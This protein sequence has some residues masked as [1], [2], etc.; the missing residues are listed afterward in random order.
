MKKIKKDATGSQAIRDLLAV[1]RDK[2][3]VVRLPSD[4]K[5]I[6]QPGYR[7]NA[8]TLHN[9]L[10]II[11]KRGENNHQY[12]LN[13]GTLLRRPQDAM[14]LATRSRGR[15]RNDLNEVWK[16]M[17]DNSFARNVI[18]SNQVTIMP[19]SIKIWPKPSEMLCHGFYF[20]RHKS[21]LR[22]NKKYPPVL[23]LLQGPVFHKGLRLMGEGVL[24]ELQIGLPKLPEREDPFKFDILRQ[25]LFDCDKH[26]QECTPRDS[27][28][29]GRPKRLINVGGI[30]SSVVNLHEPHKDDNVEYLALSHPWG[31]PPHVC[32]H[33]DNIDEHRN[34][35]QLESLP[36]TFRDA[37]LVTRKLGFQYLW[38]D[39]ICIIQGPQG[40]FDTEGRR[41]EDIFSQAYCVLAASAATSQ[42]DGFLK[43]IQHRNSVGIRQPGKDPLYV[44]EF[45]DDFTEHVLN[46]RLN[47]R[48]WVLQ[49]RVLARRT[50]YFSSKQIYWECGR[51]IRCESMTKMENGLVSFSGDPQFPR[52]AVEASR[53]GRIILYQDLYSKYTRLS[54]TRDVDRPIAIAGLEKRL[55]SSFEVSGGFG[56]FDGARPGLLQRSLLWCRA[57]DVGHLEMIDFQSVKST[58][59][60]GSA[61]PT[62]SWMAYKGAIR[63]LNIPFG[64]VEWEHKDISSPW[65]GSPAGTWTYSRDRSS[66]RPALKATVSPFDSQAAYELGDALFLDDPRSWAAV[67]PT[68]ACVIFGKLKS[69]DEDLKED[70]L[71]YVL[72]V[73][74]TDS[75]EVQCNLGYRRVGVGII[76]RSLFLETGLGS[77]R[78]RIF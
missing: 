3:L 69:E 7:A 67:A 2:L 61:P 16:F 36:R 15:A 24:G 5:K 13:S 29:V 68:I 56:I 73:A 12:W 75:M 44:C 66:C 23:T 43:S 64:R 35:V 46:S 49:E 62:W 14:S 58:S 39:S 40:D 48:G 1:V 72:L 41:M 8:D 10:K 76:R 54:L 59:S 22:L 78:E 11:Q 38:I 32:T 21:N 18:A 37:I 28:R 47:Q 33:P 60:M 34:G 31:D 30:T 45:I 4:S 57:P 74:P 42:N 51:G 71:H 52:I 27:S 65:S 25:W 53:G 70:T 9:E 50:I 63:Y 55:I 19:R 77:T 17:V 20:D 6:W 26:H